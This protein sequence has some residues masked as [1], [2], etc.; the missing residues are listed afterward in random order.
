MEL[1]EQ[2]QRTIIQ[3]IYS[4]EFCEDA[5]IWHMEKPYFIELK[6]LRQTKVPPFPVRGQTTTWNVA[7]DYD[8]NWFLAMGYE[9]IPSVGYMT[10]DRV[11]DLATAMANAAP[12]AR[13]G[14]PYRYPAKGDCFGM[15]VVID[16]V[17]WSSIDYFTAL[18]NANPRMDFVKTTNDWQNTGIA[19][20]DSCTIQVGRGVRVKETFDHRVVEVHAAD[21]RWM[22]GTKISHTVGGHALMI[23]DWRLPAR[24]GMKAPGLMVHYGTEIKDDLGRT[25]LKDVI[26]MTYLI[27][28]Q[29]V[30]KHR[31]DYR[32]STVMALV[33][34]AMLKILPDVMIVAK[35]MGLNFKTIEQNWRVPKN[36]RPMLLGTSDVLEPS[37][38]EKGFSVIACSRGS[39]V[40]VEWTAMTRPRRI[41]DMIFPGYKDF[42]RLMGQNGK[43]LF[44][45]FPFKYALEMIPFGNAPAASIPVTPTTYV[46]ESEDESGCAY[47]TEGDPL[48]MTES[49][50][51]IRWH[52]NALSRMRIEDVD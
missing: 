29:H 45:Y 6:V 43:A 14:N 21:G 47:L 13:Y 42:M 31:G 35:Q 48:P 22:R 27:Q 2:F 38:K 9:P 52:M 39:I 26:S 24:V 36:R 30:I 5:E 11:S 20:V 4:S 49:I 41:I 34:D 16:T 12:N 25:N 46:V 23:S 50:W 44:R 3:K 51:G 1:V 28:L 15:H 32:L 40:R 37:R 7:N 18:I 19:E 17:A 8:P 10:K 33:I